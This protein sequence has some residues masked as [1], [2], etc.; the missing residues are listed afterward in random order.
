VSW[1]QIHQ[2][3]G[4]VSV[5]RVATT[6][7]EAEG[8]TGED[9][10]RAFMVDGAGATTSELIDRYR[11]HWAESQADDDARRRRFAGE[12]AGI[13]AEKLNRRAVEGDAEAIAFGG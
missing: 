13:M 1:R 8:A 5:I 9:N 4:L 3:V 11:M 2:R 12:A 10:S 7:P 6:S